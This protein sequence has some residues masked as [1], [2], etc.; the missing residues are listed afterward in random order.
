MKIFFRVWSTKSHLLTFANFKFAQ[1]AFDQYRG[2][3]INPGDNVKTDAEIDAF[4]RRRGD[5]AY[6]DA[7]MGHNV[8]SVSDDDATILWVTSLA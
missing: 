1:K 4:I 6:Y 2:P 7:S 3:E 8:L 5:S